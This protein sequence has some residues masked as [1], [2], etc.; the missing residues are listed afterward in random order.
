MTDPDDMSDSELAKLAKEVAD[1]LERRGVV[2]GAGGIAAGGALG[3]LASGEAR[4]G[5]QSAGT[6]G[7]QSNPV[8]L[9]AED[10]NG[11]DLLA[12]SQGQVP[13]ADG[14]GRLQMGDNAIQSSSDVVVTD[15]QVGSLADGEFLQNSGGSLAGAAVQGGFS[16]IDVFE[17]DGTFDASD[18]DFAY[19]DVVGGGG[20]GGYKVFSIIT[21]GGAGGY[22]GGFVDL[23]STSSVS[24]T[25]GAGGVGED[26][27]GNGTSGGSSSFGTFMSATGGDLA[28][29]GSSNGGS[30]SGGDI[31]ID[32][33]GGGAGGRRDDATPGGAGGDSYFGAGGSHSSG[34]GGKYGGGG[35]GYTEDAPVSGGDGGDGV[36]IVRY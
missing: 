3:W 25:V 36:V 9:E 32:G 15:T 26:E 23:S 7:S 2:A 24:V 6:I 14:N 31:N 22:A 1:R 12:A 4:A 34:Q 8:D 29:I 17:T 11:A 13:Q 33:G 21:G 27:N 5:S 10:L 20:G 30:G 19:V 28:G 16:N 18:V 35:G